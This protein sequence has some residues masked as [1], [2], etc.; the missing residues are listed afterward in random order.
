M[1]SQIVFSENLLMIQSQSENEPLFRW[2]SNHRAGWVQCFATN[3]SL[4]KCQM[5]LIFKISDVFLWGNKRLCMPV[6]YSPIKEPVLVV[7]IYFS[8]HYVLTATLLSKYC[9]L[10]CRKGDPLPGPQ[11]GLLSNTR[12]WIVQG[13]TCPDKARDFIGKG[14]P[15][16]EQ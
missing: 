6:A 8:V 9:Y 3:M 16:G 13:D 11:T 7:G 10:C 12:K 15:D 5:R 14:H 2:W 4:F 1:H